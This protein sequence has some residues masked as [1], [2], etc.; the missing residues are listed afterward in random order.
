MLAAATTRNDELGHENLGPLSESHGFLS[1]RA[2]QHDL[3]PPYD[4]WVGAVDEL[5]GLVRTLRVRSRLDEL[6]LLDASVDELDDRQLL[7][8]GSVLGLLAHAY[9]NIPLR[10]PERLPDALLRPWLQTAERLGRPPFTLSNTDYIFD[11]WRLV[12]PGA[13]DPMRAENLRL[14][15]AIWDDSHSETFILVLVELLAQSA[16]LVGAAARAQ[17]ACLRRDDEGLKAELALMIQ[18]VRRLTRDSLPKISANGRAGRRRVDPVVWTKLFAMLP[19]PVRGAGEDVRNASG[20]ETPYFHLLDVVIGRGSYE[21]QLG[22]EALRF[23]RTHP[24]HWREFLAAVAAVS[25]AGYVRERDE[26]ELSG[27]F[28]DLGEAYYG[29]QGLLA[30]H[31]LK[32]YAYMEAAF[33]T[34]RTST[35]TGF[36]GLFEDRPWETVDASFEAARCERVPRPTAA[37]LA[38]VESVEELTPGTRRV[39]LDTRGLGLRCDPGD[40]CVLLSDESRTYAVSA[41]TDGRVELTA[42][43]IPDAVLAGADVAVGVVSSPGFALPRDDAVPIIMLAEGVDVAPFVA[44]LAARAG[45][46]GTVSLLFAEPDA[47]GRLPHRE[48]LEGE[49]GTRIGATVDELVRE[50]GTASRLRALMRPRAAGRIYVS[51]GAGFARRMMTAVGEVLDGQELADLVVQHRYVQN[52]A[53]TPAAPST[54]IGLSGLALHNERGRRLWMAVDDRVYDLTAFAEMHPGGQKLIQSYAGMDATSAYRTV[55][56]H[57]DPAVRGLL[58]MFELGALRRPQFGDKRLD[59]LCRR[60]TRTLN[61]LV[62]IEN[63]HRLDTSIRLELPRTPFRLQFAIEAHERFLAQTAAIVCRRVAELA[64][65]A[66]A[67]AGLAEEIESVAHGPEATAARAGCAEL[68]RTLAR[69]GATPELDA[70]LAELEA[71]DAG[72]LREAKAAIAAGVERFERHG[73]ELL[74]DGPASLLDDLRPFPRLTRRHL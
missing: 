16:P 37:R 70:R 58:S 4:A 45:T 38:R 69:D 14:L 74:A 12:D 25:I 40:R 23:R 17:R 49:P 22:H 2:P 31:R 50:P 9:N 71:A 44:F 27:L 24:P 15:N 5:P 55:E 62:E 21:T 1:R 3:P 6:P 65:A 67:A 48:Q 46:P 26:R 30:R 39:V 35:V 72:Y 11:N 68:E 64:R 61:A 36:S 19:L 57:L 73:P 47:A 59:A 63:A 28:G 54:S 53:P 60:W 10:P 32:A 42:A 43:D 29:R 34:G 7:R 66:D 13:S 8:A 20:A 41:L 18:V 51:G 56:H 52:V 33:K